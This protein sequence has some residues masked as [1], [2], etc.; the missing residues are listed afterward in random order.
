VE[1]YLKEDF[2]GMG[3][4]FGKIVNKLIEGKV[5]GKDMENEQVR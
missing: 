1:A 3:V 2:E 4:G 5:V